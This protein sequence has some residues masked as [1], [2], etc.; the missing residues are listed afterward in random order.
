MIEAL[1]HAGNCAERKPSDSCPMERGG[2][3]PPFFI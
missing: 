1:K 3:F 2:V